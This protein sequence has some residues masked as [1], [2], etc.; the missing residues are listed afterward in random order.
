M[1]LMATRAWKPRSPWR[2][3]AQTEAMPPAPHG[4]KSSYWPSLIPGVSGVAEESAGGAR[5]NIVF[6]PGTVGAWSNPLRA[7]EGCE[8]ITLHS[9]TAARPTS[10]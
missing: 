3:A 2:L 10:T 7:R 6:R 4:A 5:S 1:V 8:L 9:L